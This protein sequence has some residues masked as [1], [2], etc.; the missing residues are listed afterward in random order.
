MGLED[1]EGRERFFSKL[2]VLASSLRYASVFHHQQKMIEFM[3]HMDNM[4]TYQNLS[5][6]S[7]FT[8]TAVI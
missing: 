6:L 8:N 5:K 2:N 1:L 3:K 7:T 4:E